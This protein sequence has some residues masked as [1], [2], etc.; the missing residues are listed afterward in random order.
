MHTHDASTYP[1]TPAQQG[2]LFQS[3]HGG[4]TGL[5]H[6][7]NVYDLAGDLD[8]GAFRDSWAYAMRRHAALRTGFHAPAGD[9]PRHLVGD[10]DT[11]PLEQVDLRTLDPEQQ[12]G[13]LAA[14]LK[15][16][17]EQR[18]VLSKAP[19]WRVHVA[20]L[21]DARW[22]VL[23]SLHY[24]LLDGTSQAIVIRDVEQAYAQLTAGETV[25]EQQVTQFRDYVDWTTHQDH[26]DAE[27]F[28]RKELQAAIAASPLPFELKPGT[29]AAPTSAAY[30]QQAVV[31]DDGETTALRAVAQRH[32]LTLRTIV[33]GV[34]ATL[35]SC[36]QST[37]DVIFGVTSPGRSAALSGIEDLAGLLVNT[38][39]LRMAV[40][41][42]MG[43]TE[44]MRGLQ[45]QYG[46]AQRHE[47]AP[48][49][50]IQQWSGIGPGEELFQTVVTVEEAQADGRLVK[51]WEESHA[52][53]PLSIVATTGDRLTLT[54]H[55]DA[56]RFD[57]PTIARLTG[58]L[59][60]LMAELV[61]KP[62]ALLGELTLLTPAESTEIVRKWN[63]TGTPYSQQLCIQQLFEQRVEK[64]PEATALLFEDEVWTYRQVN[65][66]ANQVAHHLKE[67]GLGRGDQIA[68][69]MERSAEMVPA[70]LGIL[71]V[72]ATY[73]PLDANAPVK[74]WHWILDSLRIK[75]LLTQEALVPRIRSADP[76]PDLAHVVCVDSA[77]VLDRM[78]VGNLPLRGRPEDIAYIIFTSGSTGS[79]KGVSV[80][81]FPAVNLIE[82]VNNTFSVGAGDRILFITA[83]TFDLS[84]Y[85]VFGI[86][87]AGGSIRI[88][89]GEDV[90][91]PANL[92]AYL[93]GEPI[94]FWDSAPAALMQLVPFLPTD[95]D[96][97]IRP[98]SPALRLV[99]MSGDWIPVQS[100][101]L[102]KAAFPNVNVIGLGGATEATVWS[103]FFPID[104]V[105]PAW[106][107]IPYGKPI[108]NARYYVLDRSLRPC[109]L[110]VPGDLYIGGPCLSDG[111]AN[112]PELTASKYLASPFATVPGERIYRTG[113]LARWRPD[114]NLEFLGRTDFQVKIRGYRIELG[115][116][117]SLL[118]EHPVVQDAATVVREDETGNRSLVSYLVPHPQRARS[119]VQR[120]TDSL[121]ERRVDRWREVYD[122]FDPAA[123]L[124]SEDG[125]DFSGWNS[126][127]TGQAIPVE[128]MRAWQETTVA[129]IRRYEPQT[130]LEI[131]CGT[132]LLLL[133]LAEH[134]E[135]Y[136][137]TDFSASALDAV[138]SRLG[139]DR[140]ERVV[141]H[142]CEADDLAGLAVEP[143]DTVV[144]NSVI[145]YFPGADYLRRVLDGAL[146]RV[147]DGGRI[148]VG[149]VRSFP[150]LETFHA[151]VEISRAPGSTT[152]QQLRQRVQH[153]VQQEEELTVAPAFFRAWAADSGRVSRVEI[154]PHATR[155]ANEMA[156]F[157]YQV[158]LHV[159]GLRDGAGTAAPEVDW[160]DEQLT[161]DELCTRLT[162]DQPARLRLL[163]VPNARVEEA[164]STLRWLKGG[165]GLETVEAWRAQ[166]FEPKGVEPEALREALAALGYTCA[167]DWSRHGVDG[168]YAVLISRGTDD[169]TTAELV[170]PGSA[171]DDWVGFANEPLKGEIQ[172]LLLPQLKTY[173]EDRL[174]GYMVPSELVALDALPVT[175]SGKL[176]RNALL[177]PRTPAVAESATLVPARNTTEALLVSIWERILARSPIGVLDNFFDLGGHSLLAVQLVTKI[178][179]VFGLELPVR[180]L[181]DL[182]TIAE[183]ALELQQRQVAA[184]PVPTRP[185]VATPRGG[186]LPATFDQQRLFFIDRLSPGTTS[187]TVNWLIPLPTYI[188]PAIVSNA[189]HE[190]INR[191]EPLRTTFREAD[192]QVWQVIA[193]DSPIALP[194]VDLSALP[195]E[196]CEQRAKAEIRRWWDQPFDLSAGPLLRAELIK[197][198]GTDQVVVL[199]AHHTVFDGYSI[200]VFG[201][202]FLQLCR[203]LADEVPAALQPLEVQY[204]DYAVWQQHWL[205]EDL[206][207]FHLDYWKAQLA[208][209][210]EL[211]TLPTDFPRPDEQRFTGE[212]LNR[213]MSAELT[214]QLAQLS[215]EHQVTQYIT[216]LSSFAVL[217]SRYSGQDVVVIGVPIADRYRAELQPMVGFLVST[218]ALCVDLR[219]NPSFEDVLDQVRRKLFDAQS[220][221]DIPFERLVEA[222]RP[223]RGL[224]HNPVFQVMFADESLPML[225]HASALAQPKPW[226]REL[227]EQGMSVGVSRF[228]LT[229]M[230]QSAPEGVRFGFEYSTDLF[231][232]PTV[233]RMADHF[234]LLLQSVLTHPEGRVQHLPMIDDAERRQLT[235]AAQGTRTEATVKPVHQ[236]FQ[237]LAE[238]R[239]DQVAVTFGD[240][241]VTYEALEQHSNQLAHLL[242]GCGVGRESLVGLCISR[243]VELI[244][245]TLAVLKAGGAY[246]PLDPSYPRDR[247]A[248]LV[249]DAAMSVVLAQQSAVDVLPE[250]DVTTVTVEDA[251]AELAQLPATPPELDSTTDD[252]AYVMY[253]SGS[254]GR[255]KGVAVTHADVA[256]LAMDS[257]FEKHE[258]VLLHS[259]Q[260]FDASTYELWAPLLSGGRVVLAPPGA[261]SPEVW[262][263]LVPTYAIS[264][265]WLTAALFHLFAEEDPG[266]M[267][268]LAEV[269]AG[270][271]AVQADAVRRVRA[272][273]PG[274]TIVDGYGPTETTTFATSYRIAPTD[275]VPSLIPIGRPLDNMAG[276]VLDAG[277]EPVPVGV[278][279]ELYLGG[280]GLARGYLRRPDLTAERFVANPFGSDGAGGAGSTGGAGGRLYRTG[281]LARLRVDGN[282]ELLGRAD[283][284]VKIRGF[285]VEPGEIEATLARHPDVR[286]CAVLVHGNSKRLVAYVRPRDTLVVED[287]QSFLTERLPDYMVPGVYVPVP[288][289]PLSPNGKVDRKALAEV[290]WEDHSASGR[291][292]VAP[293]TAVERQLARIWQGVLGARRPIGVH[294]SFFALGG[295]SILSLQVVFRARQ[296]GL[297]F[298]VK[299]LFQYQT[300]AELA[301]I[302]QQQQAPDLQA[303]QGLVTGPAELTPVQRWFFEQNLTNPDHFN[304]SVL[305]DVPAEADWDR[306]LRQL[307]AHHDALRTRFQ[308]DGTEWRA[309]IAGLPD[310]V[311]FQVHELGDLPEIAARVQADLELADAPLVRAVLFT[312]EQSKLLLVVHHLVVDVVSWRII[313]EDLHT[314]LRD[315]PLP[316]K[317][318]SWPQWGSRLG[319]AVVPGELAYWKEQAT[320]TRPIPLDRPADD[321]SIGHSSVYEAV[322][323]VD[324]TDALLHDVPATFNTQINDVLLTAVAAAI[325]AWTHDGHVRIDLE[326]HGR[327]DLFAD[328]DVTRTVGWFTTISPVRLPVPSDLTQGLKQ[329]KELLHDRPRR[330]I[331]Y[332]LLAYGTDFDREAPA[333]ISF[334]HLGQFEHALGSAGPDWDAD[335]QRPY[336]IDIVSHLRDGQLHMEW[337]YSQA[338]DE[339]TIKRVAEQTLD[340]LRQLAAE[341]NRAEVN[342]Y[343]PSDLPLSGLSQKG[344]DSLCKELRAHPRWAAARRPLEDCYPQ[345]P[346]QQGLWFQSQIAEG[347]GVY[348]V[349][350]ILRFDHPNLD[351]AAFR[352]SWSQVMRRH[353]ILRTSF[354]G[355]DA[356]RPLQLVWDALDVPL[357]TEDWR[358]D[359]QLTHYLEQDRARAFVP[360]DAPQWRLLLART[361]ESSYQLVWSA[362]HAILDG[363]SIHLILNDVAHYYEANRT[364]ERPATP[365]YRDYVAWL[366]EQDLQE[367]EAYWRQALEEL[368]PPTPLSAEPRTAGAGQARADRQLSPALTAEL[369]EFAHRHQLT[370]NTVLQGAWALL[371]SRQT[372]STDVTFGTITSGRP[373]HLPSVENMVGLFINTLPLR[374]RT[375]HQSGVLDWLHQ[376]QQ[377][378]VHMRQYDY[379]PLNQIQ[380]WAALPTGTPLFDTLFVFENYPVGRD[381]AA[382]LQ[383]ELVDS[384]ERS[385]YP[386]ALVVAV[387]EAVALSAQ[388]DAGYFDE[389]TV[390][391]LLAQFEQICTQL[392]RQPG[393]RLGEI[394][395]LTDEER[396]RV[397]EQ[398]ETDGTD[399]TTFLDGI[400]SG[401]ERFILEQLL[402]EV[403]A[404]TDREESDN[405]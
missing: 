278:A 82:W 195:E 240:H 380:Q 125:N 239:P 269:W 241:Q 274:L 61:G 22:Q 77:A 212:F 12:A 63:D 74:R 184:L 31:L 229:L 217:L 141:L 168:S 371:L 38:L 151:S 235:A 362:H 228:D 289:L 242:L 178:R 367:A 205:Q 364:G 293:R 85:D 254:T 297:H 49:L 381:D 281:D 124:S 275:D 295:D 284:Q 109:P 126:S 177:L 215:R 92:L 146:D 303:E 189:L 120:Q 110:D 134:C 88:A 15:L 86:L 2:I 279:G 354:S 62:Q 47:Y 358:T 183:V 206:L 11:V 363:W 169:F 41:P 224:G 197:L 30:A 91:E 113:D 103:N 181:F 204:A 233:A 375:P 277:M 42:S 219:G 332:G 259:P 127:Y 122:A 398:G 191:H 385:N 365:P 58:H 10:S 331:G 84:V 356:D 340:T 131:G 115:E 158:V 13:A 162:T 374:I 286:E 119:V 142:R 65:E 26:K 40:P 107:S 313:V 90:Q 283:D 251:W 208:D 67:L 176:D 138:R 316:P 404:S 133:P 1:L 250:S 329:I 57:S 315:E 116:I 95:D 157:R 307:L 302:A 140:A 403:Q 350:L 143:V 53:Y 368:Q 296:A 255:P 101:E 32:E 112:E 100:P 288:S 360:E 220:H 227:A 179:Q 99:F 304:Q 104:V 377:R 268:G 80:A 225:D 72:G 392:V 28:W 391:R 121:A 238:Q 379:T 321:N 29:G 382:S 25:H 317:T 198:S 369:R 114:G 14:R 19:L 263:E 73:V 383:F 21:D 337:T 44:W 201:Q 170:V 79:P 52:A 54:V 312:G 345:T 291:E 252:L 311:P 55:Y 137:G 190:L 45:Q 70:L 18:F 273:C 150:L 244:V 280:A 46:E 51:C 265:A 136:Y 355:S 322:L 282:I 199:S 202:E 180:L 216:M 37:G 386:L 163:N 389:R 405:E 102:L 301:P 148:V 123:G 171:A 96:G 348:H 292:Y 16:D 344:I 23:W 210:P 36:Y 352:Q 128:Q 299:H 272:A 20:R 366:Q 209:A 243:S 399:L 330:G 174:P 347:E 132:G 108:Q 341:A 351:V 194:E 400:A 253:T 326:G 334:N 60:Q 8:L 185:L 207:D 218:V 372:N 172:Q 94:T 156:M 175:A 153:R 56:A 402:A 196:E 308:Y 309:E 314:L 258:C 236:L 118:T 333:Q 401:E 328:V 89:T 339:R 222:L 270:G 33:Q 200:G 5:Y 384:E 149:D 24:A 130:V 387:E 186:P 388:Y 111:Y 192:G 106:S 159:G 50:Q 310:A 4:R 76:L 226:M 390:D 139:V 378:N 144:I 187:Y 260:A 69:V 3:R 7:Q 66:R 64:A 232:E 353:P 320:P 262:R 87:A 361:G 234:E 98:A 97:S 173:L 393:I 145:Q 359:N 9:E 397:L 48:L 155:D 319:Q 294:D 78:P 264:A 152:R 249:D 81:H 154:R 373:P 266:C 147:S 211:L 237:D 75:C 357:R 43:W 214:E 247:L 261:I 327:E 188:E 6:V 203:A 271:D 267:S 394:T 324:E 182:P 161:L 129:L 164:V 34:W 223:V 305:I 276:L 256:Y 165:S 287:L 27:S 395:V 246:V 338:H 245:A 248:Y 230:I 336:L 39:P 35:L 342:G 298:A 17:H 376:L 343:S 221:Q 68:I 135:R 117:D 167:V 257:R 300:I 231:A 290:P 335:N 213:Q 318:T 396:R 349:Q 71:K 285:R 193:P 370:L 83:L 105:D 166:T 59:R 325:G 323:G 93:T 346:I 160:S 306:V